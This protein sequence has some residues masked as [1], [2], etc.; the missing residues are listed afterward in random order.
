MKLIK[1]IFAIVGFLVVLMAAL[2]YANI[3]NFRFYYGPDAKGATK[4]EMNPSKA[5][6]NL[7]S[8][9]KLNSK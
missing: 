5:S 4:M 6:F 1:N 9:L 2:G 3:G 8:G 7:N